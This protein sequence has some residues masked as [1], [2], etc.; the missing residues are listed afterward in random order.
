MLNVGTLKSVDTCIGTKY[1]QQKYNV[2][3]LLF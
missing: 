3:A 1:F 2:I